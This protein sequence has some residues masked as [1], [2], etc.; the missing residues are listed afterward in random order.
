MSKSAA[1]A[2]PATLS[3][4][5]LVGPDRRHSRWDS[6]AAA[7]TK[8]AATPSGFLEP[9]QLARAEAGAPVVNVTLRRHMRSIFDVLND[10][11]QPLPLPRAAPHAGPIVSSSEE[12]VEKAPG[13]ESQPETG[14]AT[15]PESEASQRA[16]SEKNVAEPKLPEGVDL[17]RAIFAD[18]DDDDVQQK[19]AVAAATRADAVTKSGDASHEPNL[20]SGN[21]ETVTSSASPALTGV[22]NV[23]EQTAALLSDATCRRAQAQLSLSLSQTPIATGCS[24]AAATN[25]QTRPTDTQATS[26]E[27]ISI[28]LRVSVLQAPT[29]RTATHLSLLRCRQLL[30]QILG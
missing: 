10:A 22:S 2:A 24:I 15:A 11:P 27:A 30:L 14:S 18:S 21:T 3:S 17:F 26:G 19:P 20:K 29:D 8:P 28:E 23:A 16:A 12:C 5:P 9:K 13:S 1:T 25:A 4:G 7:A 6:A